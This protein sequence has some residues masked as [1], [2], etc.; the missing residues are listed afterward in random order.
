[1]L[2]YYISPVDGTANHGEE[3]LATI[4]IPA[5]T[6]P[7]VLI[8]FVWVG[9]PHLLQAVCKNLSGFE[10]QRTRPSTALNWDCEIL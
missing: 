9:L 10:K 6:S 5:S 2:S 3:I 8:Q 7:G 4:Q 1:M